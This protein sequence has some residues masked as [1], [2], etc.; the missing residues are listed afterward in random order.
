M[1]HWRYQLKA[2]ISSEIYMHLWWLFDAIYELRVTNKMII[3]D[4]S[5]G[6]LSGDGTRSRAL[7]LAW[8]T[9]L[10]SARMVVVLPG[11]PVRPDELPPDSRTLFMNHP[12]YKD[13]AAQLLAISPKVVGHMG[14]LYVHQRELA[15]TVPHDSKL[16]SYFSSM[17]FNFFTNT[18]C[19]QSYFV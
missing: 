14:L 12:C 18:L 9:Q 5:V 4:F 10:V 19:N 6:R 11:G 1:P 17:S 13:S 3:F 2:Q 8:S 7:L 16:I 15:V